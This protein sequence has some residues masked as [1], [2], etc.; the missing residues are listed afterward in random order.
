[1]RSRIIGNMTSVLT[2]QQAFLNN[3]ENVINRRVNILEDIKQYQE[4]LSYTSSKVDY[5]VGE[6]F[7]FCLAT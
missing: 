3:F 5:S 2:A 6:I 4:T 7:T 1:M